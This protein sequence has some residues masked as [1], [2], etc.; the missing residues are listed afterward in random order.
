MEKP[1]EKADS[2]KDDKP[3]LEREKEVQITKKLNVQGLVKTLI[4]LFTKMEFWIVRN[5]V[6]DVA[7]TKSRNEVNWS[8]PAAPPPST[9][10]DKRGK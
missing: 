1:S 5:V 2:A 6:R 3:L 4:W 8:T 7:K 9:T 10:N